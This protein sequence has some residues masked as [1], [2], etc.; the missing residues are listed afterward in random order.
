MP[1]PS[2]CGQ[3]LAEQSLLTAKLGELT[4]AVAE[5]LEIH[6]TALDLTH[7]DAKQ[8]HGAYAKVA[9]EHRQIAAHLRATSE[10]MAGYRDLPL[11]THD[12]EVMSSPEVRGAF[13]TLIE[14][15]QELLALLKERVEQHHSLL[16]S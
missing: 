7:E 10:A 2:S 8:E 9:T 5:N 14:V 15:E 6:M 1:S 12:M 4:D 13:N 11:G 16:N 3:G